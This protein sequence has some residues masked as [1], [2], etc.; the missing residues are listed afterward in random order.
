MSKPEDD[1]PTPV[2]DQLTK[3]IEGVP[4]DISRVIGAAATLELH[5]SPSL[6]QSALEIAR[7]K[8][9]QKEP[10]RKGHP[11][12][13]EIVRWAL[14]GLTSREPGPWASWCAFFVCQCVR[15]ALIAAGADALTIRDWR[16]T[17]ASGS[18]TS[19][20][21]RLDSAGLAIRHSPSQP[22]PEG[23]CFVF[24]GGDKTHD[25]G[26]IELSLEHVGIYDRCAGELILT[27]EGNASATADRVAEGKHMIT[28]P[29]VW[30]FGLL[31]Y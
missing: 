22:I 23:A 25:D 12:E 30:G 19:L 24:F 4:Q 5:G 31:P 14:E 29:R 13:G 27:I 2:E 9:G 17:Y 18:C 28:N 20:W 6:A 8:L 21:H 7:S 3:P 16:K 26:K 11:N 1:A 10:D 15:Q